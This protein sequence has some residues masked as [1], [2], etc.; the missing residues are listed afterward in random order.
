MEVLDPYTYF[1]YVDN[2][3]GEVTDIEFEDLVV[4]DKIT[5]DVKSVENSY[6]MTSRVQLLT[7]RM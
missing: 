3:S 2:T 6:A 1:I 5:V 7:Q 4:G